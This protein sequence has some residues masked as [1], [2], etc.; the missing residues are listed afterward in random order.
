MIYKE[1]FKWIAVDKISSSYKNRIQLIIKCLSF[2][3][4]QE[5]ALQKVHEFLKDVLEKTLTIEKIDYED[6]PK[7]HIFNKDKKYIF[8]EN[9]K[10]IKFE[11]FEFDC[12]IKI[13]KAVSQ[14][15]LFVK[16]SILYTS[17]EDELLKDWHSSK[18][19]I[20][21]NLDNT[22]LKNTLTDF[23]NIYAKPLDEKIEK[24]NKDIE[25]ETNK[26]IKFKTDKKGQ[27]SWS[28]PYPTH[29][30]QNK[31]KYLESI[32]SFSISHILKIVNEHTGFL[33]AFTHIKPHYSKSKIEDRRYFSFCLFN[34]IS[35]RN[36]NI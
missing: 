12:Y 9:N 20:I 15:T 30:S 35:D 1:K 31:N 33:N 27:K 2:Y 6:M 19:E 25:D 13:G 34:C 11:R 29:W 22:F 21:K 14:S 7:T 8:D 26:S 17:L 10:H 23:I 24:L 36:G 4:E 3:G 18:D 5:I 28:F 16:N 32:Q